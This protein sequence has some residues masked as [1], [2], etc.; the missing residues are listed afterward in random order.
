MLDRKTH[1]HEMSGASEPQPPGIG[2]PWRSQGV[3]MIK[4]AQGDM[5]GLK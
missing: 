2:L 5:R 3:G 1:F 4:A